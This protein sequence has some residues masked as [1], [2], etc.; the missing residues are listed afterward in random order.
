M[1]PHIHKAELHQDSKTILFQGLN[2]EKQHTR[3][4]LGTLSWVYKPSDNPIVF[5]ASNPCWLYRSQDL[6]P[7]KTIKG[8]ETHIPPPICM[9]QHPTQLE[10]KHGSIFG[11]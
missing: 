3:K 9:K 1:P 6:R 7:T 2:S 11:T 10:R 5:G 8:I 4:T